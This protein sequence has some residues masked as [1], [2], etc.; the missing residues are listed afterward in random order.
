MSYS[1]SLFDGLGYLVGIHAAGTG[2][3]DVLIDA[4]LLIDLRGS[5]RLHHTALME[6]LVVTG[7]NY[8]ADVI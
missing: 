2:V 7:I 8:L 4:T 6:D 1:E 5:A 3:E